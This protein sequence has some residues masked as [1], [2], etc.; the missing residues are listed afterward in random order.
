[1]IYS[2][3][4]IPNRQTPIKISLTLDYFNQIKDN[5]SSQR[6]QVPPYQYTEDPEN[7]MMSGYIVNFWWTNKVYLNNELKSEKEIST[8]RL[9]P[10]NYRGLWLPNLDTLFIIATSA[11]KNCFEWWYIWEEVHIIQ[12]PA[13]SSEYFLAENSNLYQPYNYVENQTFQATPGW[14]WIQPQIAWDNIVQWIE[15]VQE[16]IE[17]A[18][19]TGL[20]EK[21]K[22]WINKIIKYLG[23]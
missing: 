17:E 6:V 16:I 3:Q 5:E 4:R 11:K 10:I 18:K 1:V 13:P 7:Y 22:E 8:C 19:P 12:A 9:D 21:I 14:L 23:L 2:S 15:P 20:W